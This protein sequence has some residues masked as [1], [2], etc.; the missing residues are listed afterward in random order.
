VSACKVDKKRSLLEE[1][2]TTTKKLHAFRCDIFLNNT[3]NPARFLK[4][5]TLHRLAVHGWH[6]PG[7][8]PMG[9]LYPGLQEARRSFDEHG[10]VQ[11]TRCQNCSRW[12]DVEENE[13]RDAHASK[14]AG[15]AFPPES[16][17]K[18][19]YHPGVYK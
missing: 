18:C 10:K 17:L 2:T 8:Y 15:A 19:C 14:H 16:E 5:S 7:D 4:T 1:A 6:D 13:Q 11:K 9:L 3:R 12:Y